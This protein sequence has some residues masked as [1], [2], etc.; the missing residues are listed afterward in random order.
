LAVGPGITATELACRIASE[1][2]AVPLQ[3]EIERL[4]VYG[5]T[6]LDENRRAEIAAVAVRLGLVPETTGGCEPG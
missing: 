2:R 6:K 4:A 1:L 5:R 3:R